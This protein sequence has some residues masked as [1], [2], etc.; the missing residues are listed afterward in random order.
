MK[1]FRGGLAFKTHRLLYHSTLGLR[2][3]Q[4]KKATCPHS[5]PQNAFA[6][7]GCRSSGAAQNVPP[8]C[9]EREF[10]IDNLL[11]RVHFIIVMM[12][13][14]GLA[15]W[16]FEAHFSGSLT[17]T[18]V[19]IY[20]T[21]LATCPHSFPPTA[22]AGRGCRSSSAA[23]NVHSFAPNA[24]HSFPYTQDAHFCTHISPKPTL[25]TPKRRTRM[26][27]QQRSARRTPASCHKNSR[28]R[29]PSSSSLLSLQVPEG[30]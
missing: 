27:I 22:F 14:T 2:V 12:R 25:I 6:G 5:F 21:F 16:E 7:P 10:F 29:D 30:P 23:Q 4:K 11:V 13:W 3:I 20:N 15:P 28:S 1:R 24:G 26:L 17:S 9:E 8:A 19:H 18:F